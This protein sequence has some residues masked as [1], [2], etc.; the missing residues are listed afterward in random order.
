M[1]NFIGLLTLILIFSCSHHQG[2]KIAST[3]G[4]YQPIYKAKPFAGHDTF[5]S[6][7]EAL[8][9]QLGDDC[10]K[11]NGAK[12]KRDKDLQT[13]F[14]FVDISTNGLLLSD[15]KKEVDILRSLTR[16]LSSPSEESQ[17]DL[18]RGRIR[19]YQGLSKKD[20]EVVFTKI[21]NRYQSINY[22]RNDMSNIIKK[23]A[24]V[25]QICSHILKK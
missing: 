10:K 15:W 18:S 1:K 2:R 25:A 3:K 16:E 11:I 4:S 19:Y 7:E 12:S 20:R 17:E 8:Q 21:D 14:L 5:A 23:E 24:V 6:Y 22:M 13:R 9:A